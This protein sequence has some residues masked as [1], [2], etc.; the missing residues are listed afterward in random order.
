MNK[1]HPEWKRV[2][3]M[4]GVTA[5][6]CLTATVTSAAEGGGVRMQP[7]MPQG[8]PKIQAMPVQKCMN[9]F[10]RAPHAYG[11]KCISGIATCTSPFVVQGLQVEGGNHFSYIC[12][13]PASIPK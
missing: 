7:S 6:L 13:D 8:M 10:S 11:Y 9:G 1:K 12:R 4:V 5:G 3:M 2:A